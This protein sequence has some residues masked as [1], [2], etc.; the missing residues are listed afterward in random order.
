ML[1]AKGKAP[2]EKPVGRPKL[3]NR[4]PMTGWIEKYPDPVE[5]DARFRERYR[6]TTSWGTFTMMY[7]NDPNRFWQVEAHLNPLYEEYI[8]PHL[9]AYR[10]EIGLLWRSV[11]R[12]WQ[13]EYREPL[14]VP[15]RGV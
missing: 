13:F 10:S 11:A 9:L 15:R 14:I 8:P 12:A 7:L 5:R 4:P 1:L 2:D 6:Q 3:W